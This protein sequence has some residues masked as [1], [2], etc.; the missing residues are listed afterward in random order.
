[1]SDLKNI[2]AVHT[3]DLQE[4]LENLGLYEDFRNG[5]IKC[6]ICEVAIQESNLGA[7][8][9]RDGVTLFSCSKLECLAKLQNNPEL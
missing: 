6:H 2:E 5:K 1:M 9:T 7:I 4:L 8:F 3:H